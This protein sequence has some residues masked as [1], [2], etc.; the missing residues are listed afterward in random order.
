ME[1][2]K[3]VNSQTLCETSLLEK[4]LKFLYGKQPFKKQ[5]ET[6]NNK[7]EMKTTVAIQ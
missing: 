5:N 6:K 4:I 3:V 1:T 2:A 7:K